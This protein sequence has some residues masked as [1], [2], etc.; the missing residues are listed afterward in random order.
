[1]Y[2]HNGRFLDIKLVSNSSKCYWQSFGQKA[3]ENNVVLLCYDYFSSFWK[4]VTVTAFRWTNCCTSL[5]F[6]TEE[7]LWFG[8]TISTV[9]SGNLYWQLVVWNIRRQKHSRAKVTASLSL[10]PFFLTNRHNVHCF[11]LKLIMIWIWS[12][13]IGMSNFVHPIYT[14]LVK[15]ASSSIR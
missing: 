14:F 13:C 10:S 3:S 9:E 2:R 6:K 4:E 11:C 12:V 1:M 7:K 15:T 5:C 8:L